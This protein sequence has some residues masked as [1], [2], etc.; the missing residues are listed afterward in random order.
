MTDK[1]CR[2]CNK[3]GDWPLI[4]KNTRDMEDRAIDGNL[5]C[6][7]QLVVGDLGERGA[8]YV[9]L[10]FISVQQERESA[11]SLLEEPK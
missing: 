4:C 9:V 2:W 11:V 7:K 10:N 1:V 6:L 3:T 5:E 8:R